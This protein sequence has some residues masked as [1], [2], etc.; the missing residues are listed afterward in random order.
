MP[1]GSEPRPGFTVAETYGFGPD[2]RSLLRRQAP[3]LVI[4]VV[5]G[6][7]V[8]Y[9]ALRIA[10]SPL[11]A[12]APVPFA[13]LIGGLTYWRR[14]QQYLATVSTAELTLSPVGIVMADRWT[15]TELAWPDIEQVGPVQTLDSARISPRRARRLSGLDRP[16]RTEEGVVGRG[17]LAVVAGM[18][19]ALRTQVEGSLPG[20]GRTAIALA[21]FDPG[22]RR[23]RI[24][25]WLRAYRPDLLA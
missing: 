20:G 17:T 24:G 2:L 1:G 11:A 15:R 18:P 10:G 14:R 16:R 9:L 13:L 12:V 5:L 25:D 7:G 6:Y 23:G 4:S 8:L 3:M 19:A 22:W 21:R